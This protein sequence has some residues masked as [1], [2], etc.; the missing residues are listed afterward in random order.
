MSIRIAINGFGRIGRL[1]L[2]VMLDRNARGKIF[3]VVAINDLASPKT[4]AHLFK[5]D[6]VFGTFKREVKATDNSIIADNTEIPVTSIRSLAE[7]EWGKRNVDIVFEASGVFTKMDDCKKHIDAGAKRVILTA[8]AKG[9]VDKTVVIGVNHKELKQEH[10]VISNASCT[11]NCLA[12][13]VKVLNER[14]GVEKAHMNT[15]HAATNDQRTA[16]QIH[17][18]LRRARSALVNVIPTT[19][20]AARAIGL[21]IPELKGK[22]DGMATRV[23][24][25]DGS[26]VDL[27]CLLKKTVTVEEVNSAVRNAASGELKGILHYSTDPLVSTDVIGTSYSAVFDSLATIVTDGNLVKVLAWYDNEY[28]YSNRCVDLAYYLAEGKLPSIREADR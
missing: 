12:P 17:S 1:L 26:L 16:D 13:V 15:I 3:E 27:T 25:I 2:R 9:D 7:L 10:K 14:F 6:S 23:P 20:G 21:V 24:V 4:L 18:D 28:G 8:P 5:Y 11:T 22:I 19:T